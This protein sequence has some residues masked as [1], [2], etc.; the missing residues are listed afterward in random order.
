VQVPNAGH[1][2]LDEQ[3]RDWVP[4]LPQAWVVTAPGAHTP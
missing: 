3:V 1:W 2:Q 4:Q